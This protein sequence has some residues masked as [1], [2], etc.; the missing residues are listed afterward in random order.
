MENKRGWLKWAEYYCV[1]FIIYAIYIRAIY[2]HRDTGIDNAILYIS[3]R[4]SLATTMVYIHIDSGAGEG[5]YIGEI[6]NRFRS[7]S[8]E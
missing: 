8:M 2:R 6:R 4:G 7:M 5:L 1:E 3:F